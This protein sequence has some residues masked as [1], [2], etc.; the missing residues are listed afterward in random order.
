MRRLRLFTLGL[1]L[2]ALTPPALAEGCLAPGDWWQHGSVTEAS[3]VMARAAAQDVV[4]IGER[5]DQMADHR[6][7]LHTLA[8]LAAH[9]DDIVIGLEMLPRRAQPALDAW[10]NGELSEDEL[11]RQSRWD[12]T[13]GFEAAM[14][15]PIF[16]FARMNRIPL[17]ALNIAPELRR[18]LADE[19]FDAVPPAERHGIAPPAAPSPAYR[20]R[21][22]AVYD[23]HPLERPFTTFLRAQ[24][25]WDTAM[26]DALARASAGG[27]LAVGIMG[28]GHMQHRDG[29]AHQ[30]DKRGVHHQMTLLPVPADSCRPQTPGLADALYML[31][32]SPAPKAG[33]MERL[34]TG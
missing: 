21:L 19:G 32:A 34:D 12:E 14:Y 31:E 16:H 18:R 10:V 28:R 17:V 23:A 9:R 33:F 29:V 8:G 3:R 5:H 24:L 20:Q 30:L 1:M 22:R 13:W 7:E 11:L 26:A 15:L 25:A 4:L 2:A 27:K 6:F